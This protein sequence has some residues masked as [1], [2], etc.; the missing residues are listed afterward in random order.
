M[1]AWNEVYLAEN[2]GDNT[3][4]LITLAKS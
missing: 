3:A 1:L 4:R 2:V